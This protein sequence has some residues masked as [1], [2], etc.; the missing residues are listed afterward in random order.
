MVSCRHGQSRSPAIAA[1]T[2]AYLGFDEMGIWEN[3]VKIPNMDV[4]R[5]VSRALGV[6]KTEEENRELFL[7]NARAGRCWESS[8]WQ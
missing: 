7:A 2:S 8:K 1:A 5:L 6:E 3:P 4:Y